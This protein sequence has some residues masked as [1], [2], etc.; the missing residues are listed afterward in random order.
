MEFFPTLFNQ[1][2]IQKQ[3][4]DE[5]INCNETT[6]QYGLALTRQQA[7]QLV[8]TRKVSLGANGRMEFGGG[9]IGNII[10]EF[11]GSPYISMG[12]YEQTLHSLIEMF[13][14]YKNETLDLISD[15]DLI[16]FMKESFDGACQGSLELLSGRE[17]EKLAHD[18]RYGVGNSNK[19]IEGANDGWY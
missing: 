13:Y 6:K 1:N 18:L 7:A 5:V 8:E 9:V 3:A 4:A 2:L 16:K 15:G 12:N 17:L 14:Y 11:C 19:S 10:N